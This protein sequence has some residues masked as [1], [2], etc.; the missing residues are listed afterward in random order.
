M[1][2]GVNGTHEAHINAIADAGITLGCNAE[3]TLYC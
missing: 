3:G 2:D 1:F